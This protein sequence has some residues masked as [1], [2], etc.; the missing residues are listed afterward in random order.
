[1]SNEEVKRCAV[2]D[3]ADIRIVLMN[4][5]SN[6]RNGVMKTKTLE[7]KSKGSQV[8]H[9]RK[10]K[11]RACKIKGRTNRKTKKGQ[12]AHGVKICSGEG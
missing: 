7:C 11:I 9:G 12:Q 10:G 4:K 5:T 8:K 1:M 3:D 6:L 2:K